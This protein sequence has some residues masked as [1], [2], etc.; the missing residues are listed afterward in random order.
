MGEMASGIAHELN[1]PLAAIANYSQ[2]CDRLLA[3]PNADIEEVRGALKEITQQAV[4]AGDI[5]RK[6]RALVSRAPDGER[7]PTDVNALVSELTHLIQASTK[8][9]GMHYRVEFGVDLP[10]LNVH[11]DEIQQVILNL[12]RNAIESLAQMDQ[13]FREI[14]VRTDRT[15]EGDVEIAV[16]DNGP[17]VSA[18]IVPSLFE[19]FCTSKST[20]TG[21][22]LAMSRTIVGQHGGTLSYQPSALSG[23]CFVLRLPAYPS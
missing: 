7:R 18:N 6:L 3:K 9:H 12:V 23:A 21:L 16:C 11:Q 15:P 17:G 1:Q 4:R 8:S 10:A 13:G 20:G 22:G 5:I 19:P 2:A 14:V